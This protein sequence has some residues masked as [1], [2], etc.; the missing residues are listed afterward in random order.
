VA[1][2]V[3]ALLMGAGGSLASAATP[4]VQVVTN[5]TFGAILANSAGDALYTLNTDH[6]GQSTCH[7]GCAAAWP[8]LT[9]AAGTV[10]SAGPGVNGTVGTAVQSNG[11]TQVTYNGSPLYTFVS[12]T[13]PGQ[14][15]GNNVAGF[16]V[17]TA[18]LTTTTT[19]TGAPAPTTPAPP[20]S[21]APSSGA[22]AASPATSSGGSGPST[23]P[24]PSAG[25]HSTTPGTLAF[26][27]AGPGLRW[28]LVIGLV[29]LGLGSVFLLGR[30]RRHDPS[31]R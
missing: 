18:G 29:L 19:T 3:G 1:I 17:V 6:N 10:P 13:A 21:S 26:T 31:E 20:P 15:T 14:V 16:S 2:V 12:D 7:G 25:T 8:A 30:T 11:T 4:T 9:V 5:P 28:V 24:A 27:G 22:T 23:A